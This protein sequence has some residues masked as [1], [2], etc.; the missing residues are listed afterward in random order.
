MVLAGVKSWAGVPELPR[1]G[2]SCMREGA[3]RQG[4]CGDVL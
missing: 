1:T 4:G 2:E 3:S